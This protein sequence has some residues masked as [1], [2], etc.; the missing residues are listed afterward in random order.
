MSPISS[1]WWLSAS[2]SKRDASATKSLYSATSL[3]LSAS[4]LAWRSCARCVSQAVAN[5]AVPPSAAPA[6]AE[7]AEMYP[8]SKALSAPASAR[9]RVRPPGG[10]TTHWQLRDRLIDQPGVIIRRQPFGD[11]LTRGDRRHLGGGR[12]DFVHRLLLRRGD[13]VQRHLLATLRRRLGLRAAASAT[14]EPPPPP[15]PR[16][17]PSPRAAPWRGGSR[18]PSASPRPRFLSRAASSISARTEAR[19]VIQHRRQRPPQLPAEDDEEQKK[20]DDD[21]VE[22]F[23]EKALFVHGAVPLS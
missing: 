6:R 9:L 7:N 13:P 18:R 5:D 16:S 23:G 11:H 12:P 20:R 14:R 21:P 8:G 17:A 15:R 2:P 3:A 1:F 10:W 4:R 22:G 19:A